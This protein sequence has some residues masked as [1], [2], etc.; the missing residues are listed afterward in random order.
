MNPR[1]THA[2]DAGN[3]G[4]GTAPTRNTAEVRRGR[5]EPTCTL[6]THLFI[7]PTTVTFNLALTGN[8]WP[9]PT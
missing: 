9:I 6:M 3:G 2:E 1:R 8:L 5:D 7:P 4:R